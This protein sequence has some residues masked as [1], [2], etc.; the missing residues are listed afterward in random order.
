M[1]GIT[2]QAREKRGI[3]KSEA[4]QDAEW[5]SHYPSTLS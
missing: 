4:G 1:D 3:G 5:M 2:E